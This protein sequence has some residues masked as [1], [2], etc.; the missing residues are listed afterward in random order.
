MMSGLK[1]SL[2]NFLK[3]NGN[4]LR[5]ISYGLVLV[6]VVIV[7]RC[8]TQKTIKAEAKYQEAE[9][10]IEA[11]M[12]SIHRKDIMFDSIMTQVNKLKVEVD[13]TKVENNI[14]RD[15]LQFI[16]PAIKRMSNDQLKKLWANYKSRY[17]LFERRGLPFN[18]E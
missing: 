7:V 4:I 5:Y 11:L 9:S 12:D 18:A 8:E 6:T 15:S 3:S 16:R 10:E 13:G 2:I 17:H 14:L 1:E